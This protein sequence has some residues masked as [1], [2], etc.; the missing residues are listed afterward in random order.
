MTAD[1]IERQF[2]R[3]STWH[4]WDPHIHSPGT[5]LADEYPKDG[6]WEPFLQ[7]LESASPTVRAIGITDYC[8]TNSYRI[9]K[10]YKDKGRLRNCEL[11]FPNIELRLEIGT[12]RS[13]H[14]N[15]HLLVSPE[16]PNH[17]DEL[18]Q[19]LSS[20]TFKSPDD[21]FACNPQGLMRLGR[22]HD[23]SKVSDRE[24]LQHGV[25][26]FKVTI[27]ELNS[28]W[29]DRKWARDNIIIA[30]A[31]NQ[32]GEG[33]VRDSAD[34]ALRD[35]IKASAKAIFESNPKARE[36]W[37]GN[38]ADSKSELERKYRG[39][40]PCLHGSDAHALDRVAKPDDDRFCWIKGKPCFDTLRQALVDA[41]RAFVG[42]RPPLEAL[43]SQTIDSL[44]ILGADWARNSF[45]ALNSGLVAII[46]ARGSGKSALAEMIA[47]GCKAFQNSHGSF[48]NRARKHLSGASVFLTWS[49]ESDVQTGELDSPDSTSYSDFARAQ[50]LS[51]HF[52]ETLCAPDG[53]PHLLAEIERV[54]FESQPA[55]SVDGAANFQE[56][57][58]LRAGPHRLMQRQ[59]AQSINSISESIAVEN[60]KRSQTDSLR[61]KV[62]EQKLLV[63]RL[64]SDRKKLIINADPILT[65]KMREVQTAIDAKNNQ[66][67]KLKKRESALTQ[68][69]VGADTNLKVVFPDQLAKLKALFGAAQLTELEWKEFLLR[70]SGEPHDLMDKFIGDTKA[71]AIALIGKSPDSIQQGSYIPQDKELSELPLAI[72]QA[73]LDRLAAIVAASKAIALR[74]QGISKNISDATVVLNTLQQRLEDYTEAPVRLR[75]HW[76][77]REAAFARSLEGLMGEELV[78]RELYAPIQTKMENGEA[79]LKKL[80]FS[81][82]RR[83]NLKQWAEKGEALFDKRKKELRDLGSLE[84]FAR[85]CL[86]DAWEHGNVDAIQLA[87]RKF[88]D[89][90][91]QKL[92]A[93]GPPKSDQHNYREWAKGFAQWLFSI[94]HISVEYG[95]R[96]DGVHIGNLSPGTR[97]I[98]LVMVYLAL[99]DA[100]TRPLIIDQPEENLDPYSIYKE[101]VPLFRKTKQR[102]QVIMVTH[103]ANLVVNADA[104]QVIVASVGPYG[105]QG[106]PP[107]SYEGGGLDE[108]HTRDAVCKILEGGAEAFKERA[109]RLRIELPN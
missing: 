59:A 26:Q 46:G 14:V 35:K 107:I 71:S 33:G 6:G 57:L 80:T 12:K 72:V 94:E 36:Y 74:Y 66:I 49:D 64:E 11:L 58:E 56:L 63:I 62:E 10:G 67:T 93:L 70:Y 54:I 100:D 81:V 83:A 45:V 31:G 29:T 22:T 69:R 76:A 47:T 24:A 88:R 27:D 25:L 92:L 37:L 9:L 8:V 17:L 75:Q 60:E 108:V 77:N 73:E 39:T 32:D 90:Y 34:Q 7:A 18:E 91:E 52:V 97:G 87:M 102:R 78:L 40:K 51:Q 61:V 53:M 19:F 4:R 109:K 13:N 2:N 82:T 86:C 96:Y 89:E 55:S 1:P 15:V 98:V 50:Y 3:G 68:L 5:I 104:D 84:E 43:P 105:G 42:P 30:V 41:E 23:S 79:S 65:S 48:L 21:T 20:L 103:N 44:E 101:L 106:L 38:G 28:K 85:A 95:I 16:D 99:D